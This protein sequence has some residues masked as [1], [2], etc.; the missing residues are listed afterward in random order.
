MTN[1]RKTVLK[2]VAILDLDG[3][4]LKD[5]IKDLT[6]LLEIHAD[7]AKVFQRIHQYSED[8][9]FALMKATPETDYEMETRIAN[10]QFY[11]SRQESTN[12]ALYERLKQE[13][14]GK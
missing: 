5:I 4:F 9:Y 11:K 6:E 3:Y 7:N 14:E 12:R 8:T 2:E 1:E 13:F 10:E